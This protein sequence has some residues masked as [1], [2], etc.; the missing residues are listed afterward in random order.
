MRKLLFVLMMAVAMVSQAQTVIKSVMLKNMY[1][2]NQKLYAVIGKDTTYVIQIKIS[3]RYQKQISVGL[4]D[5][6]EAIRLLSFLNDTKLGKG[7]VV[8]LENE[9]HNL[10]TKNALGG[11]LVY[12]EGRQFSGQLSKDSVREFIEAINEFAP[13]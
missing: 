7:D 4:G 12:S 1:L 9:T 13:E 10:V 5:R 8:D 11:L 2:G 6:N 3:N